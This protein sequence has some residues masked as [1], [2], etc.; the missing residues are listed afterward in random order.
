MEYSGCFI[1]DRFGLK[2]S[3]S[4]AAGDL[5]TVF[6]NQ[7]TVWMPRGSGGASVDPGREFAVRVMA[8]QGSR[9]AAAMKLFLYQEENEFCLFTLDVD[10]R[11]YG[12]LRDEEKLLVDFQGFMDK[13]VWLI[14]ET[15]Q[16]MSKSEQGDT[17]NGPYGSHGFSSL[18]KRHDSLFFPSI[19]SESIFSGGG[20]RCCSRCQCRQ[21]DGYGVATP[22]ASASQHIPE[23]YMGFDPFSSTATAARTVDTRRNTF[24][25]VLHEHGAQ[26]GKLEFLECNAFKELPHLTLHLKP[27]TDA[28]IRQY[29]SFRMSEIRKENVALQQKLME[30][31]HERDR[32]IVEMETRCK[33]VAADSS[34]HSSAASSLRVECDITKTKLSTAQERIDHLA[35]K[36]QESNSSLQ[37]ALERAQQQE[38]QLKRAEE[39]DKACK[40]KLEQIQELYDKT[41]VDREN[42]DNEIARAREIC[43][44]YKAACEQ[45]ESRVEDWRKLASVHEEKA[46]QAQVRGQEMSRNISSLEEKCKTAED[47]KR[48]AEIKLSKMEETMETLSNKCTTMASTMKQLEQ[49]RAELRQEIEKSASEA[50][51]FK[52]EAEQALLK[53]KNSEKMIIWLNKQ[54]T[55]IQVK[56]GAPIPQDQKGQVT[57]VR[58]IPDAQTSIYPNQKHGGIITPHIARP[59][60]SH[61]V[62]STEIS[63]PQ[64]HSSTSLKAGQSSS[65]A[66]PVSPAKSQE[67]AQGKHNC[68]TTMTKAKTTRA[69]P[70][71]CAN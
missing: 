57:G 5:A 14:R 10:E 22:N 63:P 70:L 17:S 64:Q 59:I 36:L 1:Q 43:N 2:P 13:V 58:L 25:M 9:G 55:A 11:S 15:M 49:D 34:Q 48:E 37:D 28:T 51:T 46:S 44:G 65:S 54:L 60:L 66:S 33:Q 68:P 27:S 16:S 4:G 31:E 8:K 40:I 21:S 42:Q 19:N 35:L 71:G 50:S 69:S 30:V 29:M 53:A 26:R 18:D 32:A 56:S 6:W 7:V 24:R 23:Q 62:S 38:F 12:R 41:R 3:N 47:R 20:H 61:C 67:K 45:A 39:D 52:Q